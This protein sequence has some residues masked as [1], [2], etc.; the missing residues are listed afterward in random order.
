MNAKVAILYVEDDDIDVMAM[1]REFAKTNKPIAI[2]VA[3]DGKQALDM[4]Y[5]RNGH[6]KIKPNVILLDLHMPQMSGIEFLKKLRED[7]AFAGIKV[8]VLT[9]VYTTEEKL[10]ASELNVS[11]CIIQPVQ[12]TDAL[13]ILWC[14]SASA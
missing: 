6:Q 14:L 4:L 9:G 13:N 10:A 7:L 5:G 3:K 12:Y 1:R 2:V 8:F 11:G